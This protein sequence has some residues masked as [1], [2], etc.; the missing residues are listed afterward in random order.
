MG[1]L[2][3]EGAALADED[4]PLR[5][6]VGGGD[7][8]EG[9]GEDLGGLR[10]VGMRKGGNVAV[11]VGV[12]AEAP[13]APDDVRDV[14]L[15]LVLGAADVADEDEDGVEAVA[16]HLRE[17]GVGEAVEFVAG[18]RHARAEEGAPRFDALLQEG[19]A[20][21]IHQVLEVVEGAGVGALVGSGHGHAAVR[22]L[23]AARPLA[24]GRIEDAAEAD[25]GRAGNLGAGGEDGRRGRDFH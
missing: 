7:A 5:L 24:E 17:V 9:V 1:V 13:R 18:V 19:A 4:D 12:E 14:R 11:E 10:V 21:E 6:R 23:D 2:R 25:S 15:A 8:A 20:A 16:R 22:D 3:G